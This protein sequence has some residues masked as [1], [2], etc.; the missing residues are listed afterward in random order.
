MHARSG[1]MLF[2]ASCHSTV[3]YC[4]YGQRHTDFRLIQAHR[5]HTNCVVTQVLKYSSLV[6]CTLEMYLYTTD[7]PDVGEENASKLR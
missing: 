3:L 5:F 6:V 1:N 4:D 2:D 7:S